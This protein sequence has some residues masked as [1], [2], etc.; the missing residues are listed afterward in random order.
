MSRLFQISATTLT[1]SLIDHG[2][3]WGRTWDKYFK[4]LK[5]SRTILSQNLSEAIKMLSFYGR[6]VETIIRGVLWNLLPQKQLPWPIAVLHF[7]W[8]HH[9]IGMDVPK[10]GK[11]VS[12]SWI[13]DFSWT[14]R[15]SQRKVK[16]EAKKSKVHWIDW[17]V[18]HKKNNFLFLFAKSRAPRQD[19]GTF[20]DLS[21]WT[22]FCLRRDK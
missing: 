4:C 13:H 17:Q 2:P 15:R 9:L 8:V 21:P 18:Y 19:D 11:I 5:M 14:I 22:S 6:T 3:G 20:E 12:K 16:C 1:R 10:T 7:I